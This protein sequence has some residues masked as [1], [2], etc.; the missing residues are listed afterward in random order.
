MSCDAPRLVPHRIVRV[1]SACHR[2]ACSIF[3][4]RICGT[5]IAR[6]VVLAS[7]H[8]TVASANWGTLRQ[9]DPPD[10]PSVSPAWGG[11]VWAGSLEGSARDA[12]ARSRCPPVL[13]HMQCDAP[14][15]CP[16]PHSALLAPEAPGSNIPESGQM[17]LCRGGSESNDKVD[18]VRVVRVHPTP[19]P[20]T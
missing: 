18:G 16:A 15:N 9:V 5:Y 19:T 2:T 4:S 13:R 1:P 8:E 17:F 7:G 3:R 10:R 14:L 20:L 11:H 12:A 6:L